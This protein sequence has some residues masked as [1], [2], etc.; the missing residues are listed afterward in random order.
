MHFHHVPVITSTWSPD[1][2]AHSDDAADFLERAY[3]SMLDEGE[4]RFADALEHLCRPGAL[5]AV[6][7][8]AAG[9]DRTG[10]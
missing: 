7:H 10:L 1:D 9:K 8:C 6:F 2:I 5:P 3:L 4:E